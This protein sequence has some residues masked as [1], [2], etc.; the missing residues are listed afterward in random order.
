MV[1]WHGRVSID[2]KG[3]DVLVEAFA[4]LARRRPDLRPVL[5]LIG[6]GYDDD[7]LD[8]LIAGHPDVAIR[9]VTTFLDGTAALRR[10]L[11]AGD[12]YVL[13]SRHEGFPVSAIEA[14]A[15]GLPLVATD[16]AGAP[17]IVGRDEPAGLL[18]PRGDRDA[19][20]AA[21]ERLLADAQLRS[22]L[23]EAGR[24]RAQERFSYEAVGS[25][26]TAFIR[27]PRTS[28]SEPSGS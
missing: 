9:R 12:V 22:Q 2:H 25:R 20:E 6:A 14:I 11:A 4:H 7:A 8:G 27:R 19:M 21:I 16:V 26:V 10:L 3:L 1:V 28:R 13:A 17:E 18:V 5:L 24:R 15:C 23:A